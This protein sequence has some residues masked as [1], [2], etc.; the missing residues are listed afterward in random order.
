MNLIL[1]NDDGIEAPGIAALLQ[2]TTEM[3]NPIVMAPQEAH[4]GCSHRVTTDVP[5]RVESRQPTRLAVHGTPSDC[6]RVALHRFPDEQFWLLSGINDGANL[7]VDVWHS[8]TVAAV[9]EAVIHGRPGI[10]LSHYRK[11]GRSI[12][13]D[14]AVGL[15]IPIL[16][17]LMQRPVDPATFW[18]VNL[19]SLEPSDPDPEA[20][21]CPLDPSPLPLGYQEEGEHLRYNGIYFDRQRQPGKDVDLCFQGNITITKI[22]LGC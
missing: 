5:I 22:T 4:S 11:R 14:R 7:G 10:A 17:D 16:Q 21:F 20:I 15:I 3:G 19:P 9:R 13:W 6:A 12:D 1:T 8:G 2:A 18:N